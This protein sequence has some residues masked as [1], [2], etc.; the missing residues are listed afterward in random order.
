MICGHH[1]VFWWDTCHWT[2]CILP[3]RGH[4]GL[5]TDGLRWFT[6]E[7]LQ[8]PTAEPPVHRRHPNGC[9]CEYHQRA[10]IYQRTY[11]RRKRDA[12]RNTAWVEKDVAG[13]RSTNAF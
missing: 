3:R 2:S 10:R 13:G 7:G 12:R 9:D 8:R 4:G 1:P 6:T 5:H 11:D